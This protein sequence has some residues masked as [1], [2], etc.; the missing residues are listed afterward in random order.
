M[1]SQDNGC[2]SMCR[3]SAVG[4]GPTVQ[5]AVVQRTERAL[6]G[7]VSRV[8]ELAHAQDAAAG[9]R[10]AAAA[11]GVTGQAL[12]LLC[13]LRGMAALLV[14]G[15]GTARE[16][17]VAHMRPWALAMS[18]GCGRHCSSSHSS[19]SVFASMMFRSSTPGLYLLLCRVAA[20][21][22]EHCV[23]V[24]AL[25]AFL[26]M[27]LTW[28]PVMCGLLLITVA[29]VHVCAIRPAAQVHSSNIVARFSDW[30]TGFA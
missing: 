25:S 30:G 10:T 23:Q 5:P 20:S 15:G 9:I 1:R 7:Q 18:N 28:R 19:P 4:P 2:A 12:L 26:G 16:C 3:P 17:T 24:P 14:N 21:P 22:R 8:A 11:G 27:P 29:V 13:A 6:L